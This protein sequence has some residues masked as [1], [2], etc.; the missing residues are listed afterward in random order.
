MKKYKNSK[1]ITVEEYGFE[2]WKNRVFVSGNLKPEMRKTKILSTGEIYYFYLPLEEVEKIRAEQ[3]RIYW[4]AVEIHYSNLRAKFEGLILETGNKD[5]LLKTEIEKFE[6]IFFPESRIGKDPPVGLDMAKFSGYADYYQKAFIERDFDF[7]LIEYNENPIFTRANWAAAIYARAKYFEWLKT[8]L[9]GQ[10]VKTNEHEP[11]QTFEELF[12]IPE[13]AEQCLN[14][15]RDLE[16]PVIDAINNYIG[17]GKKGVFALWVKVL[18][19]HKPQPLI[20][21]FKDTVYKDLLNEKVKGLDLSKDA[22]EFRKEYTRLENSTMELDIKT[23][24]SQYSQNGK[25][26]K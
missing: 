8:L 10:R 9:S 2:D 7:T 19:N 17:K 13:Q 1:G 15:L 26:G 6:Y 24:L 25:L 12:Y 22:S 5:R 16:P 20:K 18:K 14:I 3:E 21:H 11:P 23:I 4:A